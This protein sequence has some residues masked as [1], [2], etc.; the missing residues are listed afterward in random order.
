VKNFADI[1]NSVNDAIALEQRW[2]IKPE[3]TRGELLAP[4]DSDFFFTLGGGSIEY[5]QPYESSPHRSGRHHTGIIKKKKETSWNFSTYFNIDE[6]QG[7]AVST[8]IDAAVRTLFKSLLGKEDTTAGAQYTVTVPN[9]TF[10]L[11]ECGDKFARQ[12]RG[13]FVQGCNMNFPGDG[14]ATCEWSGNAK[15][16][17]YVGLGKSVTDNDGGN[18]IT[19]VS[20]D[21]EQFKNAVGGLVML[22][23]ANGTT[24]SADTPNGTPRKITAVSGD[25]I[26]VDGAALADAD[27]SG[28]NAPIYLAYYEPA[29]PTAINNPVT[30]LVGSFTVTGYAS[31]C[32]RSVS[33]NFA[34]DHELHDFC[35]GSDGLSGPLFTPGSRLNAEVTV[36]ANLSKDLVKL[37]NQVQKFESKVLQVILGNAAGRHLDLDLPK[38]IFNV[39]AF[40]LPET[41][42]IPVS[43]TG[44]AFQTALDAEDE[45]SVFFK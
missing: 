3:T 21:G 17:I 2:Y 42:S 45:V 18:V 13:A 4:T 44:M 33:V 37:F 38:V 5:A 23:E 1:Y 25:Q 35:Y 26:T 10:S 39:P 43:F 6:T 29:A 11:Y 41:G 24:R 30:G 16:A 19:L 40:A 9:I 27:G 12:A 34:N 14:E 36:E 20:G 15:D 31:F 7:A 22:I 28:V 32:T 8:E